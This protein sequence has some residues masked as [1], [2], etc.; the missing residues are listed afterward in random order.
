MTRTWR[1]LTLALALVASSS[2]AAADELDAL[3]AAAGRRGTLI[4]ESLDGRVRHV[5][6][7]GRAATRLPVASTF[8]I[9]HTLIALDTGAVSG[10]DH[11]FTW[12]GTVHDI[13]DWNRDQTLTSAYRVSCVWCYQDIA[14]RIPPATYLEHLRRAHYGE[15][16][17][18]FVQTAFWLDGSLS[19]SAEE[20]IAFLRRVWRRQLP[21]SARAYGQLRDVMLME[22]IG[23]ATVRAKTGW[24][25]RATP[26]VGWYVGMLEAPSGVWLFALNLDLESAA[27]LPLRR[28]LTLRSLRAIGALH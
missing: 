2:H 26:P 14:R 27:D 18:P 21:Y 12:D 28:D 6:D 25:M 10:P 9:F 11:R 3:F 20:Q 4:I 22:R 7:A 24:A 23:D 16:R 17:E 8:K 19:L 15:L 5:H 1:L 13:A